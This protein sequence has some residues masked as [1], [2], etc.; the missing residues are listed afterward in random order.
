MLKID[1]QIYITHLISPMLEARFN[2]IV[3]LIPSYERKFSDP[4]DR[5]F[6]ASCSALSFTLNHD[7]KFRN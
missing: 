2:N 5:G 1:F 7:D 6:L 3:E 4:N